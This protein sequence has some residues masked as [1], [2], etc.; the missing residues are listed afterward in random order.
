ME[1]N[2]KCEG[3]NQFEKWYEAEPHKQPQESSKV[4]C[5]GEKNKKT[6]SLAF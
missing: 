4:C 5:K 3:I 6:L 1:E 2:A